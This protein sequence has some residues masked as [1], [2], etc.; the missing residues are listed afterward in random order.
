[1]SVMTWLQEK[2]GY[3]HHHGESAF[4]AAIAA[5]SELTTMAR[6]LRQQLEPYRRDDDP[7]ASIM[8]KH[9][10]AEQFDQGQIRDIHHGPPR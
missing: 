3:H 9:D 10:M 2:F 8:R 6:S 1:M 7:F 5:T 4:R